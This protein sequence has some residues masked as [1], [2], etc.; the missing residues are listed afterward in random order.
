M[1]IYILFIN[2][3]ISICCIHTKYRYYKHKLHI[4]IE[5]THVYIYIYTFYLHILSTYYI[6]TTTINID[7]S[8]LGWQGPG[9]WGVA[10][11]FATKGRPFRNVWTQKTESFHKWRDVVD[12]PWDGCIFIVGILGLGGK[13]RNEILHGSWSLFGFQLASSQIV[14]RTWPRVEGW[15]QPISPQP[16]EEKS[17]YCMMW[18]QSG[19]TNLCFAYIHR[20]LT[21]NFQFKQCCWVLLIPDHRSVSVHVY[22]NCFHKAHQSIKVCLYSWV[23]DRK[24]YH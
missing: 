11:I 13:D 19:S 4:H 16:L 17:N 1:Y 2:S 23:D 15:R 3:N 22:S 20:T 7:P 8:R 9:C 21:G 10:P 5:Y 12:V 24:Q 14:S 18:G 6:Y